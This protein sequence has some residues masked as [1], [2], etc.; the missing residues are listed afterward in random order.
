MVRILTLRGRASF[1]RA[2]TQ[3]LWHAR[4]TFRTN[5]AC[6]GL[7]GLGIP[8]KS[9]RKTPRRRAVARE[10]ASGVSRASRFRR[11]WARPARLMPACKTHHRGMR[12]SDPPGPR[13]ALRGPWS[14][15]GD[16]SCLDWVQGRPRARPCRVCAHPHQM[17]AGIARRTRKTLGAAPACIWR[18]FSRAI[19]WHWP[20]GTIDP[21]IRSARAG[22]F[23]G[24][25]GKMG[26][27]RA[28]FVTP[29]QNAVDE[30]VGLA[31]LDVGQAQSPSSKGAARA[32]K[33][34]RD[35]Q[36]TDKRP[37]RRPHQQPP[38][39]GD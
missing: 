8:P 1:A 11:T 16:L 39:K 3:D 31:H 36:R 6:R 7:P 12:R 30:A 9:H 23:M 32:A 35:I 18:P 17:A 13:A 33:A 22:A 21:G 19:P 10:P 14:L 2:G 25:G 38:R 5:G 29:G 28:N 27:D 26:A 20:C 4:Y 15:P 37:T 24:L 34:D